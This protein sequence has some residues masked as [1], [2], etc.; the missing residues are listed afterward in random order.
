MNPTSS[1]PQTLGPKTTV[2]FPTSLPQSECFDPFPYFK[3]TPPPVCQ[4]STNNGQLNDLVVESTEI[5]ATA[6]VGSLIRFKIDPNNR[7]LAEILGVSETQLL[8]VEIIDARACWGSTNFGVNRTNSYGRSGGLLSLWDNK[9]FTS[10]EVISSCNYLINIGTWEGIPRPLMF[11]NINGPQ[12]VREKALLWEEL[13]G[14]IQAIDGVWIMMGDFNAVRR[15]EER[16]NSILML[17][18]N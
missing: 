7:I 12:P 8:D 15:S 5:E 9:M 16:F 14:I 10:T 6:V 11:A 1:D 17:S 2:T 3:S 18:Y 4:Q 13:K